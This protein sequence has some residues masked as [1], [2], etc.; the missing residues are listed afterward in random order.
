MKK[1]WEYLAEK[2]S[3]GGNYFEGRIIG[4]MLGLVACFLF[5]IVMWLLFD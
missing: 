2:F 1:I 5:F 3:D 4:Y